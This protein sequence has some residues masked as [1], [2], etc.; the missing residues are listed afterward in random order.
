MAEQLQYTVIESERWDSIAYKA[1]GNVS[2][3]GLLIE[4]NP[5]LPIS[6]VIPGGTVVNIPVI[7]EKQFEQTNDLLPPWKK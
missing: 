1:Y 4:S 3:M 6:E 7:A 2:L 5:E